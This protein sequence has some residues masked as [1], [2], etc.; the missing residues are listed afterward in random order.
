MTSSK[1]SLVTGRAFAPEPVSRSRDV[2]R[3]GCCWTPFMCGRGLECACHGVTA[4]GLVAEWDA[5]S[6]G[7]DG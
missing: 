3:R 6:C 1:L 5:M 2:C 4:A 7:G